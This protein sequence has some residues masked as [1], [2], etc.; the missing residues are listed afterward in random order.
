[1]QV[2]AAHE[3]FHAVQFAYDFLED[4]WFMEATATWAEDEL[5]D[6]VNDNVN[7]LADG[8]MGTE[9][10]RK[11]P[12]S[13]RA[14]RFWDGNFYGNWV[15][16]R[17]LTERLPQSKGGLP[18]LVRDMW[19]LADARPASRTSTPCRRIKKVLAAQ[20][21]QLR[22]TYASFAEA[23]RRT[24]TTYDEGRSRTTPTRRSGRASRSRRATAPAAGRASSLDHL[25]SATAPFTPGAA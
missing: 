25:T 24:H 6:G 3:Y 18:V 14:G 19:R 20:A 22:E 23:N 17:Y 21:P 15:F 10:G 2:T 1:M 5:Y 4:G 7:Y 8:Q 11:S 16:F 9:P 12:A 13:A